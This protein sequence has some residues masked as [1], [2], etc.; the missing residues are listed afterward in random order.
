[1]PSTVMPSTAMS[2][3]QGSKSVLLLLLL[4]ALT[5][6]VSGVPAHAASP[7]VGKTAGKTYAEWSAKWWQWV[8]SIP[9]PNPQ[10]AQGAL[11]CSVNQS[12]AV[13]FLAGSPTGSESFE[14]SCT[15]PRG[16][17][18]FFPVLNGIFV[19]APGESFTVA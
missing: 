14:R 11:D 6:G 9:A 3:F 4:V 8:F 5:L 19:N 16:K 1:M 10:L 2:R 12:G 15:V 18:L 17:S 13:W 7:Q